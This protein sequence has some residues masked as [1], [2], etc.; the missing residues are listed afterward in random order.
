MLDQ[1]GVWGGYD[2]GGGSMDCVHQKWRDEGEGDGV[3]RANGSVDN[4][5]G[6]D[7]RGVNGY[8]GELYVHCLKKLKSN[9][10]KSKS[11]RYMNYPI[12]H[13]LK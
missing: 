5:G 12:Y 1:T 11:G 7:V 6:G 13:T 3:G 10:S 4:E 9:S 2:D 8:V